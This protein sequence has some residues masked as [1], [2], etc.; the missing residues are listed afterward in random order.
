[1]A[2]KIFNINTK[3]NSYFS[4]YQVNYQDLKYGKSKL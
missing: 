2:I 4:N 1:M 3:Q